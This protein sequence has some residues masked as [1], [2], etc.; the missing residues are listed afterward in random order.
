VSVSRAISLHIVL[1]AEDL[2]LIRTKSGNRL[3]FAVP[4]CALRHPGR[5]LNPAEMPPESMLAFV[6]KQLG[7]DSALFSE[8]AR[9]VENCREHMIELQKL[10]RQLA[11]ST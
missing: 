4:L 3:D 8:Y 2:A 10:L 11:G 7:I 6:D 1:N 9:R 5:A